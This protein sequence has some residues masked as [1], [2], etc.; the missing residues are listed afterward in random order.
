[1]TEAEK[2][3]ALSKRIDAAI[4]DR[5]NIGIWPRRVFAGTPEDWEIILAALADPI[6][7]AAIREA[8]LREAAK[9]AIEAVADCEGTIASQNFVAAA[10]LEL[11]KPAKGGEG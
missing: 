1:M 10:I 2:R 11:T 7:T 6:L 4:H 8:A 9:A 3:I 5:D